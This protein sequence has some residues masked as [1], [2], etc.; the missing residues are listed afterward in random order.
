MPLCRL[1][2]G[3]GFDPVDLAAYAAGVLL[4]L[5]VDRLLRAGRGIGDAG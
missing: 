2:I 5:R 4:V 3:T 1:L